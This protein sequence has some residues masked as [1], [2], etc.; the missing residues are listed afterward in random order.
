VV[1]RSEYRRPYPGEP[2]KGFGRATSGKTLTLSHAAQPVRGADF[3]LVERKERE[4]AL[5]ALV[6]T[7][8]PMRAD[9]YPVRVVERIGRPDTQGL[10]HRPTNRDQLGYSA[11][12]RSPR[13]YDLDNPS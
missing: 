2:A 1:T 5:A 7:L 13:L 9:R 3:D 8:A 6:T 11:P 4:R 10:A 12:L